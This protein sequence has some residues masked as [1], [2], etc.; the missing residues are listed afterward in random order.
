MMAMESQALIRI[1]R[2]II[3]ITRAAPG[4]AAIQKFHM[5]NPGALES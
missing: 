2:A 3:A 4:N 5:D 1:N